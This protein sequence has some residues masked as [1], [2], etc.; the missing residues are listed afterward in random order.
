MRDVDNKLIAIVGPTASGKTAVGVELA[1]L[2]AGEVVSADSMQVYKGLTIGTEKPTEGERQGVPHHLIDVVDPDEPFSAE[3]Y[4][5]LAREAIADIQGRAKFPI[6][7]GG[8]G[9]YVRAVIDELEFPAGELSSK[10]RA[11]L[12]KKAEEGGAE[13]LH[14]ELERLDPESAAAIPKENVRRVVRALEVIS[15]TGRPFSEYQRKWN[16]RESIYALRIFGLAMDRERLYARIDSRVNK[17][18]EEGLLNEVRALFQA[19]RERFATASQ[20]LG[21]KE[22]F[23]YLEG[24]STLEEAV[25]GLKKRT[26]RFAKRQLTWFRADPRIEWV[27]ADRGSVEVARDI[28]DRLT[29]DKFI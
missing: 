13:A 16:L 24:R 14:R 4:Q 7:V 1:K 3:R 20:A 9:L 5:A 26:R 18:L 28:R 21:Y 29:E 25:D 10:A 23:D 6:L 11:T 27:E 12:R 22:F 2:V 19:D 15:L 8:T 17:Q